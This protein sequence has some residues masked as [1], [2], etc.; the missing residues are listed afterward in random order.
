MD[1]V[2]EN[3]RLRAALAE[4]RAHA[5][6]EMHLAASEQIPRS[7]TATLK[8]ICRTA[9]AVLGSHGANVPQRTSAREVG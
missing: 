7:P 4:A 9:D 2:A 3:R 1:L 8:A 5:R 6:V